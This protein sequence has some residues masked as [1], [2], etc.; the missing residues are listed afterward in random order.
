EIPVVRDGQLMIGSVMSMTMSS[1]HRIVDGAM[2]AQY[3]NTVKG[4][5]EAPATLLV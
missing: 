5:L 4:M 3:L 2:A 1:D